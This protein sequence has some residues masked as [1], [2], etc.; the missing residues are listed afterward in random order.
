MLPDN[1]TIGQNSSLKIIYP[2]FVLDNPANKIFVW[3]IVHSTTYFG[4]KGR[5]TLYK[6][7]TFLVNLMM[8]YQAETCCSLTLE[9][10]I[11]VFDRIHCVFD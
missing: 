10:T 3:P 6:N 1:C 2:R 11:A 8:V 5:T 7:L 9:E 4:L